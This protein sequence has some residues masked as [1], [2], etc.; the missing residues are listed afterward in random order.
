[1]ITTNLS[2]EGIHICWPPY[3]QVHSVLS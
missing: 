3:T 1:M 2:V